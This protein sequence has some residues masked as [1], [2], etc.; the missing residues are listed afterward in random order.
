MK[1]KSSET[2]YVCSVMPTML[3]MEGYLRAP[4]GMS[5]LIPSGTVPGT[6]KPLTEKLI[7]L[8]IYGK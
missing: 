7:K 3:R 4:L 2:R 5:T 8:N 6:N 1:V